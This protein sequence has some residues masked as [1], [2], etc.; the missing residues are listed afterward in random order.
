MDGYRSWLDEYD[1]ATGEWRV[2]ADAPEARD[3]FHAV[4]AE[5]KLYVFGGRKSSR[6]TQEDIVLTNR[7]GNIYD[8]ATQQWEAVSEDLAQPSLRAGTATFVWKDEVIFGGG[9]S[10]S[11]A[12]AHQEMDAFSTTS[13][14]W[15]DW[16]P[17][18]RGRHGAGLA[19]VD[20]Y[21]Y[22]ASGCGNRGGKPELESIE[23]LRLP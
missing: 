10:I 21:V 17:L 3:H 23:R 16:P 9:E 13:K 7:Y 20:G 22:T 8:F 18:Q 4:V 1:P 15:R 2:L 5:D 14:T 6:K 19:I 11:Q 12:I